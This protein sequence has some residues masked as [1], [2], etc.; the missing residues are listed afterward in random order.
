MEAFSS[1]A[2]ERRF[3]ALPLQALSK[4][5]RAEFQRFKGNLGSRIKI[6]DHAVRTIDRVDRGAPGMKFDGA[7]LNHFQQSF[8]VLD[9]QVLVRFAL[10]LE[11][12]R[13]NIGA[14]TFPG[15]PLKETLLIDSGRA[16]QQAERM[17]HDLRQYQRR[18]RCIIFR[19]FALRDMTGVGDDAAGMS[20]RDSVENEVFPPSCFPL[21]SLWLL[22]PQASPS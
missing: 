10:V 4:V 14:Q 16:T 5:L 3:Q 21:L 2:F 9:V 7:H 22:A 6:E 20:N 15:I 19:K 12:K 1:R 17:P 18:D 13:T 8:F 11:F